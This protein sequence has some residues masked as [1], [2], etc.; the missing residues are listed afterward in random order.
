M[1]YAYF[2]E[3]GQEQV[4]DWMCIAGFLGNQDEW[5]CAASLWPIAIKPRKKL[6]MSELRFKRDR[7]KRTLDKAG[8]VPDG[9]G[10]LPV[11]TAVKVSD[12]QD[13][14]TGTLHEVLMA[15][16]MVCCLSVAI[17]T[18]QGI[19]DDERLEIV[20]EH[21]PRYSLDLSP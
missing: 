21:Q 13:L 8:A 16:Y 9:A 3:S 5:N 17:H 4:K 19:A 14:V 12:Y 20:F 1:L 15:G 10:L 11:F 6:H 7:E 18:L 2:D